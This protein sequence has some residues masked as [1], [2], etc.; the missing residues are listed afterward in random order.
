MAQVNIAVDSAELHAAAEADWDSGEDLAL[1]V[2]AISAD[3]S[4]PVPDPIRQAFW[5]FYDEHA[6]DVILKKR[7]L[8]IKVEVRVRHLKPLFEKLFGKHP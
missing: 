2:N 8:F 3:A 4:F 6:E 7:I 5:R 1:A